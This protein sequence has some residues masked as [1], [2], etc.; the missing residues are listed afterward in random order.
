MQHSITATRRLCRERRI[1][2]DV[3]LPTLVLEVDLGLFMLGRK[4]PDASMLRR[5][6][7]GRAKL[8]PVQPE[9]VAGRD[10]VVGLQWQE[11]RQRLGLTAVQLVALVLGDYQ[12]QPGDLGGERLDLDAPEVGERERRSAMAF[13]T[14]PVDCG[15]DRP[16]LLVR[17][18]KEVPGSRSWVHDPDAAHAITQ[19]QQFARVVAG[20]IQL[21]PKVIQ[22]ERVEHLEDVRNAGVVHPKRAALLVLRHGLNHRPEDVRVDLLP[23]EAA[24]MYEVGAGDP[25]EARHVHGAGKQPAI[26]IRKR[27]RPARDVG[28]RAIL[29][30]RVHGAEQHPDHL[31]GVGRVLRAHLRNCCGEQ[32][33]A[34]KDVRAFG[35]EAEDQPRHEVVHVG[36]ALGRAPV[37]VVL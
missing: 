11:V 33:V 17:D 24:D 8:E 27:I 4:Q 30:L 26:H 7:G 3:S 21:G 15:L 19:V 16:H 32:V 18:D 20:S 35:E 31:M 6:P 14:A 13:A 37:R 12:R 34:E 36:P 9:G 29:D 25:A 2:T 23:V 5:G 10:P 1:P 28:S 22:E